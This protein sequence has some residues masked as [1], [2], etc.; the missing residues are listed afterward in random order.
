MRLLAIHP[1]PYLL[2]YGGL[3][4]AQRAMFEG[5]ASLGHQVTVVTTA[6]P[7]SS[8][9]ESEI[10]SED[11]DTERRSR[12]GVDIR[13][14]LRVERFLDRAAMAKTFRD[15][16]A[17]VGPDV[18]VSAEDVV[19]TAHGGPEF[20]FWTSILADVAPPSSIVYCA[21]SAGAFPLGVHSANG[22][23]EHA[24]CFSALGAIITVS[25]QL[26]RYI[27]ELVPTRTEVFAFPVYGAGPFPDLSDFSRGS[28]GMINPSGIKGLPIFLEAARALPHRRFIAVPAWAS[29]DEVQNRLRSLPNIEIVKPMADRNE[30]YGSFSA[31][32]VPSLWM[33]AFGM[34]VVEAML[35]GI[36]VLAS[37]YGGLPEAKLGV[38]YLLPISPL[39]ILQKGQ[40]FANM[41]MPAQD[42]RPWVNAIEALLSDP[43][44][45][46]RISAQGRETSARFVA[47]AT[48]APFIDL[49]REVAANAAI[50]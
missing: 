17:E 31:L 45:Y 4:V 1:V 12:A 34:V 28:V 41:P 40:D 19:A 32:L 47:G 44:H 49:L 29:T 46:A 35:R 23:A 42:V 13:V 2:A 10:V 36:P 39:E 26:R 22:G 43:V 9:I 30:L 15:L 27:R 14:L 3:C 37:D 33:E 24:A 38:P 11:G 16:R 50:G 20:G 6:S 5:L 18:Y 8:S 48:M 21:H 7:P 25:Q